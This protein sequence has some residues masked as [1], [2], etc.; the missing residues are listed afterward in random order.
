LFFP[1]VSMRTT[2]RMRQLGQ[3]VPLMFDMGG[4]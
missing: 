2:F 1:I 4:L 3:A